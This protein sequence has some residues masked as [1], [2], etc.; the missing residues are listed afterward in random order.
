MVIFG[1]QTENGMVAQDIIVFH[2]DT[3]EW[4]KIQIKAGPQLMAPVVQGG[5]CAV[6]PPKN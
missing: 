4:I 1:G 6:I 3:S 5:A 2:M